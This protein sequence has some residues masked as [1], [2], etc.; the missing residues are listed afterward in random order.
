MTAGGCADVP[1]VA[2]DD[3]DDATACSLVAV[4]GRP[5]GGRG[6]RGAWRHGNRRWASGDGWGLIRD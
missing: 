4:V 1:D 5:D 2:D 6:G 3:D